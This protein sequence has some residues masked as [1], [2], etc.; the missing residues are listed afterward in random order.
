MEHYSPK[1]CIGFLAALSRF[2]FLMAFPFF[3]KRLGWAFPRSETP[4]IGKFEQNQPVKSLF[5]SFYFAL[6][7]T[8]KQTSFSQI[9]FSSYSS[10][11]SI[12]T[13]NQQILKCLLAN[14]T[15]ASESWQI[16][17]QDI[18]ETCY[19]YSSSFS[20]K[21]TEWEDNWRSDKSCKQ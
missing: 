1:L 14:W 20:G 6:K 8:V 15:Q 17:A 7:A 16:K 9:C 12:I 21:T 19:F 11:L 18:S 4:D 10:F 13:L 2:Y 3:N 5:V